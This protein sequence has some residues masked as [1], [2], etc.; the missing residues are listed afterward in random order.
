VVLEEVLILIASRIILRT[1]ASV[2]AIATTP[3]K[4]GTLAPNPLPCLLTTIA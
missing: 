4:A 3:G 2:G 1:C